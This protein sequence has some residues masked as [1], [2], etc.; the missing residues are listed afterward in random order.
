MHIY[1]VVFGTE[2][3]KL[4]FNLYPDLEAYIDYN[5]V[6]DK[7]EKEY[8]DSFFGSAAQNDFGQDGDKQV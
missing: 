5:Y 3:I 1:L 4:G 8:G 6:C 7:R 2:S